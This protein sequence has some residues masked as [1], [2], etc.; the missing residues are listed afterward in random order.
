MKKKIFWVLFL[1]FLIRLLAL[2]QSLWLDEAITANVVSRFSYLDIIT[3]F[4]PTDFHP[5]LYYLFMKFWTNIFGYGEIALRF[6]SV[7]FSIITAWIVYLMGKA[8]K[9]EKVGLWVAALF[10][11][12]P[13]IIYYSQ[14]ARPY[15]LVTM[16]TTLIVYYLLAPRSSL[17]RSG[18][19]KSSKLNSSIQ[20]SN[21]AGP[22]GDFFPTSAR[23][24]KKVKSL[25]AVGSPFI[26]ATRNIVLINMFIFLS[27]LTF[28]GSIFFIFAMYL[29]LL[30][31]RKYKLLLMLS[32]G[33]IL[34]VVLIFPLFAQQYVNSKVALLDVKNW[35]L[36]LG[37]ANLKNLFL[38]PIKFSIGRIS[39]EPKIVYYFIAGFWSIFVF[40]FVIMERLR[41]AI[42]S[43]NKKILS[44]RSRMTKSN[45][46]D[47][48]QAFFWL[49]FVTL[50]IGFLA[51]FFTPVL[52]YFRFIYLIPL[53]SI[54]LA[55]SIKNNY[56]KIIT[57]SG[58]TI[59]SF[60]Y[61]L[62]PIYHREDWKSLVKDIKT[63]EVYMITSSSD[64]V[65]YYNKSIEV[66]NL[67]SL[68][69]FQLEN[70]ITVIPYAAEI[71]GLDY[72]KEL[73][74]K[75][76]KI[77]SEKTHRELQVEMWKIN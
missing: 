49:F 46:W 72:K 16:F 13:L 59:F 70:E 74:D 30:F 54:L 18:V 12:N 52:Q 55:L 75:G 28:Y 39:F 25:R 43:K 7:I 53:L 42:G 56:I 10:L 67:K 71:Y 40:S 1:G 47:E 9:S 65:K 41:G 3:K 31:K 8:L 27:F 69:G 73:K 34:A 62:N 32:P 44:L 51:S 20:N 60:I 33:F 76:Y 45:S 14:E 6:P 37:K 15:M 36:V 4:S 66:K 11:F 21:I 5:P 57:L 64:P 19:M 29:W 58:F 22:V 63:K 17:E 61:L 48:K 23:D 26:S 50:G 2:N 38:I 68:N 35:S 24:F 77:E